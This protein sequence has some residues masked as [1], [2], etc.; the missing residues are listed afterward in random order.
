M[1]S[2]WEQVHTPRFE[3]LKGD[4]STDVLIIGGGMAGL[5]TAYFLHQKGVNYILVEKERICSGVTRGTTAKLTAQHGL[6]YQRLTK[7]MGV[8]T[9]KGYFL[10]NMQALQ[11]FSEL[12]KGIE[13]DYEIRDSYVYSLENRKKLEDEIKALWTLGYDAQLSENLPLPMKTKGAVKFKNQ[14]Q[15]HPLKFICG[16]VKELNIYENTFVREM[17]G[18]TARTDSGTIRAQRVVADTHFPFINKHGLYFLKLYQSRSYVIALE[19]ASDVHGMYVDENE[20]G[21]SFRNSGNLLLL[22]GSACRTGKKTDAWNGL[23]A[24]ANVH[25]PNS[26]EKFFWAAQDCM[27][28]DG[29][30]YIGQYSTKT[31][32]F[33]VATGFNKWGMT[34]SM[35]AATILCDM[36]CGKHNE[37]EEIFDPSRSLFK[38][39]LVKNSLESAANLLNFSKKRC[40]H[41]GCALKWNKAE[42]S[43]DCPCHGSRFSKNGKVLDNPANGNLPKN[44]RRKM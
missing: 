16:I 7:N 23:R 5:L 28:L 24:F 21:L 19:N 13:C 44:E 4:V 9:A 39:Q 8:E 43:F 42:H 36:L 32:N 26:K 30:P 1:E 37:F 6:I 33:Y 34:G 22:G 3:S 14:A 12:C 18:T 38:P 31:P 35:V 40:P 20:A 25:Y 15:F 17:I 10:A 2:V 11:R 41:M 27:S 29:M